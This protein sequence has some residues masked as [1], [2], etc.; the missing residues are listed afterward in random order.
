MQPF[1]CVLR[2]SCSRPLLKNNWTIPM[3][4]FI[5]VFFITRAIAIVLCLDSEFQTKTVEVISQD[6]EVPRVQRS[7]GSQ[8]SMRFWE[9]WCFRVPG[10]LRAHCSLGDPRCP[11]GPGS[12]RTV[13]HF[14]TMPK[15]RHNI[16]IQP[17]LLVPEWARIELLT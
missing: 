10:C 11:G 7:L 13:S 15:P 1:G 5:T 6:P 2:N 16:L 9:T 4:N 17:L 3:R 8:R 14:S 12:H